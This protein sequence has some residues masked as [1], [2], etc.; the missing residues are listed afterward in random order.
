[1]FKKIAVFILV[2]FVSGVLF[3][4]GPGFK[5]MDQILSP[6]GLSTLGLIGLPIDDIVHPSYYSTVDFDKWI[7]FT[8]FASGLGQE[9]STAERGILG[10]AMK[11]G[12]TYV[13]LYYGGNFG[14]GFF[15]PFYNELN[16]RGD[17]GPKGTDVDGGGWNPSAGA[18]TKPFKVFMM[19]H[20]SS[21][22]TLYDTFDK[23]A[24]HSTHD[25]DNRVIVLV[26]LA[27]MGFSLGYSSTHTRFIDKDVSIEYDVDPLNPSSA[28]PIFYYYEDFAIA[29]GW[30]IPSISWGIA[31]DLTPNGIR[32]SISIDLGFAKNYNRYTDY[33][34]TGETIQYSKNYFEPV[35][36]ARMNEYTL[37]DNDEGLKIV[38]D[39]EYRFMMRL[40]NNDYSYGPDNN[41]QIKSI[42]GF[43]DRVRGEMVFNEYSFSSHRIMPMAKLFWSQDNLLMKAGLFL[44]ITLTMQEDSPMRMVGAEGELIKDFERDHTSSFSFAIAPRIDLAIQYRVFSDKL[45]INIGGS[46][47]QSG[48]GW[49][50]TDYTDYNSGGGGITSEIA[51]QYKRHQTNMGNFDTAFHAGLTFI[52]TDNFLL[53]A[54]TGIRNGRDINVFG[55]GAGSITNFGSIMAMITF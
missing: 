47:Q 9:N 25:N 7:G 54:T 51:N 14:Y 24:A 27:N 38:T 43:A 49:T 5:P 26:G 39:A 6:T 3:A 12:K 41:Q 31:N 1:M 19:P 30:Q 34:K 22:F 32:P 16:V 10:T 20:N 42:K 4:Q 11:I 44:P 48:L 40:F 33:R 28:T 17:M 35:V 46:F 23:D 36:S 37:L 50:S 29:H 52:F 18:Q 2:I 55:T 8:S 21:I 53:D 45:N 15:E 13:G